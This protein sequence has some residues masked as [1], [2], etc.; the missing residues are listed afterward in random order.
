MTPFDRF[1]AAWPRSTRKESKTLCLKKWQKMG[2]DIHAE[3]IIRHVEYMKTTDAW[4]KSNGQFIPAPLVYI[5]QMRWDGAEIPEA[6]VKK[7]DT[8]AKIEESR[9][10]AI[11]PPPEI[12]AQMRNLRNQSRM[13]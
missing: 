3:E 5:N 13:H 2:L 1:W 6:V 9:K 4:L 11:P 12:L 8:L 10:S 7:D